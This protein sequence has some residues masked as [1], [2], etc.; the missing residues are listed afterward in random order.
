MTTNARRVVAALLVLA[1]F[2]ALVCGVGAWMVSA[3]CG[4]PDPSQPGYLFLGAAGAAVCW[5]GAAQVLRR[6]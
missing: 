5:V 6:P 4:S 3:C 1:G 2:G